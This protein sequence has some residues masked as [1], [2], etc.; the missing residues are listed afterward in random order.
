MEQ[1]G[2]KSARGGDP[3]SGEKISRRAR[4]VDGLVHPRRD[5]WNR[6]VDPLL[7]PSIQLDRAGGELRSDPLRRP[8]DGPFRIGRFP[9]FPPP[10]KPSSTARVESMALEPLLSIGLFLR[11]FSG[12]RPPFRLSPDRKS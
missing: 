2:R 6:P 9:P 3:F 11:R 8:L 12:G 7:F 1:K 10:R 5:V 4:T